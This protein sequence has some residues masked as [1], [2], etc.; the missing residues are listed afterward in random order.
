MHHPMRTSI[1]DIWT[2][3]IK[4]YI[5]SLEGTTKNTIY[6]KRYSEAHLGNDALTAIEN[7]AIQR[8]ISI[9]QECVQKNIQENTEKTILVGTQI[10]RTAPNANI[11]VQQ[12]KEIFWLDIIIITHDDEAKY[13]YK[14]FTPIIENIFGAVNIWWGSTEIVVWDQENL[15][16]AVTIEIG[17]KTLR[18]KFFHEN[19]WIDREA[20]ETFLD[21]NIQT[22][23]QTIDTLFIT[24]VQDFYLTV[25][26]K[27]WFTF[28]HSDL[29]NHPIV[30]DL[31]TMRTFVETLRTTPIAQLK[32]IYIQ[33]P[34]FVDNVAIGQT[35]YYKVAE[36]YQAKNILPSKN[37]LTD[38]ILIEL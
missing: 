13:L 5:F 23:E 38:G 11:F 30:F 37:D 32:E 19:T 3:S 35:L 1:I 2:Q 34:W 6:Y 14:W 4:H 33:D 18:T 27:L 31:Q 29:P 8:N 20:M 10:L 21:Q 9:L 7:E 36:K 16:N 24:G 12:V 15:L 25:A 28:D 26:E 22:S 17:V